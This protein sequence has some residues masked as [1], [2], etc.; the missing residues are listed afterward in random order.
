MRK[1][2]IVFYYL[3]LSILYSNAQIP[4]YV[5]HSLSI[6][7]GLS[8]ATVRSIEEDHTGFMWFGTED[9][10]NKYDGYTFTIYKNAVS[11]SFSVSS[12]NIKCIYK[13]SKGVLLV[14]TRH[15]LNVYDPTLD[16]FYNFNN[17]KYAALK[18]IKGDIESII[19]DKQSCLWVLSTDGLYKVS[20]LETE[21]EHFYY[22]RNNTLKEFVSMDVD[23]NNIF[24]IGTQEGLL[25]FNP[26]TKVFTDLVDTYGN[27]HI[28]DIFID[29]DHS[30]WLATTLGIK[31]IKTSA[32]TVIDYTHSSINE[33]SLIGNNT[34]RIVSYKD[35]LLIAI[36]GG[37]LDLYDKKTNRFYHY[38]KKSGSQLNS[39]NITAIHMD[40]KGTLW[41]GTFL[42]GINF[43][44]SATNLFVYVKNNSANSNSVSEGVVT[45]FLKD[46]DNN[47]WIT[48]DGGGVFE[49]KKNA[50]GFTNYTAADEKRIIGSNAALDIIEDR[51][52][53]FWI[54][55]YNGGL[56]RI[57]PTG[58]TTIYVNDPKNSQSLGWNKVKSLI[59]YKDEIWVSS[60]GMGLSVFNK[61]TETFRRYRNYPHNPKSLP[62]DWSYWFLE[63]HT[64][65][66]WIATFNGL[67][68]YLPA[69]DAFKTYKI[70]RANLI[71]DKNYVFDIFEDCHNQLWIG[72]NG[73]GLALFNRETETFQSFTTADGLSDNTVRSVIEDDLGLL[74]LATNN[75]ITKFDPITHKTIAYTIKDGLPAG[76][77]YYNS[78]YK[79]ES[80]KIY[81]GM[82]DGYLCINTILA[83]EEIEFP[84]VVLTEFQ[85]FNVPIKPTTPNSPLSVTITEAHS[86]E[87]SYDKNSITFQ[88]AA[89]NFTIPRHNYYSYILDG[90]DTE[91]N[92]AG[93]NREA[94]YTNL[95]PGTYILKVRASNNLKVFGDTFTSF[96]I[97]IHPPFWET[98]WF[99]LIALVFVIAGI[100]VF[101]YLRTK[102]LLI[103]S[104]HLAEVVRLRTKELHE[105]NVDLVH[106]NELILDQQKELL[107][108]KYTLE[109]SNDKLS[110]WNSF[111]QKLIGIIGHD[112]RGPLQ[113]FSSLLKVMDEDSKDFVMEKLNESAAS[114]SILATDLLSWVSTQSYKGSSEIVSFTWKEVLDKTMKEIN[115]FKDE[116]KITIVIKPLGQEVAVKGITQIAMSA[117]RNILYNAIRFSKVGGI[118]EIEFDILK[119]N[120]LHDSLVDVVQPGV[121]ALCPAVADFEYLV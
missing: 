5:F 38:N 42:N 116:K 6:K 91:W 112:I 87:L 73:G 9:G 78:K 72:T 102:Q 120:Q 54:A 121:R 109:K 19:E 4:S 29:T 64:G 16:H 66:L 55:T 51:T 40:S 100:V 24:Y 13:D 12:N 57:R 81:F 88:F 59:E 110:E 25:T 20:S 14:G 27:I 80:G 68:K 52:G 41:C 21:P 85:L 58:A 79:G 105:T 22:K 3:F 101:F 89:L 67:S 28:R 39:N 37:G 15:G 106:K 2:C 23:A 75:G 86:V 92:N 97:I 74:W 107:D 70:D 45:N 108:K 104:K 65:T 98:W 35:F 93:K 62:S 117:L 61:K 32:G 96:T 60:F 95:D 90:F 69:E 84:K 18:F 103:R 1:G 17:S 10:L 63:D 99:R 47:F 43:S 50:L 7:D 36:D 77:F 34:V 82:N 71:S 46:S 11:D 113:R 49:K 8:E 44:N 94:K 76:S 30:I 48:T 53:T 118:I 33:N 111:Q 56:S 114:L 119:G 31:V 115:P 26:K 83:K